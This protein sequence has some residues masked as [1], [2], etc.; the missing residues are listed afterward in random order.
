[1]TEIESLQEQVLKMEKH[2]TKLKSM[3]K[4]TADVIPF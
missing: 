4:E 1:M 2:I 3:L